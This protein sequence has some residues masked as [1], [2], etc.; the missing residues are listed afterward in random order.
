M[1]GLEDIDDFLLEKTERIITSLEKFSETGRPVWESPVFNTQFMNPASGVIYNSQNSAILSMLGEDKGYTHPLYL[2]YNQGKAAGLNVIKGSE[3]DYILQSF[4]KKRELTKKND[5]GIIEPLLDADGKPRFYMQS[6]EKQTAVFNIKNFQGEIPARIVKLINAQEQLA[7]PEQVKTV[8]H[9]LI[10]T[11]PTPLRRNIQPDG[12]HNFYIPSE[13]YI[14]VAPSN[15]FK[16]SLH[17]L[18]T[19]L[20]E[21]SH[22]YG[23]S[24]RKNRESLAKYGDDISFRA[25]EELVANLS[26]QRIINHF[27]LK[28]DSVSGKDIN[29]LFFENHHSY[30]TGWTMAGLKA[31]PESVWL[32]TRQADQTS[33]SIIQLLTDDLKLK[34]EKNPT[35]AVPEIVSAT[36]QAKKESQESYEQKQTEKQTTKKKYKR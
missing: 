14:N 30:D 32:A 34:L 1:K 8:L 23:H 11:M 13:D 4:V 33:S 36:L 24:S 12:K 10:E 18:S 29:E 19:I 16:S 22:S 28:L 3:A 35:L 9:S 21:V 6:G 25:H 20:H 31:N 2:T 26:C 27:G 15:L 17:E 5:K 7:T